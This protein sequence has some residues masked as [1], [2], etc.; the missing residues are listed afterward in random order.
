MRKMK[1]EYAEPEVQVVRM[2]TEDMI[3]TSGGGGLG[4]QPEAG[5]DDET[6]DGSWI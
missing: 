5:S 3:R 4:S 6:V 2:D 1:K